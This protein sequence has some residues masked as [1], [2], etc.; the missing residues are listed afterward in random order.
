MVLKDV[1]I[2]LE[3]VPED[4]SGKTTKQKKRERVTLRRVCYQD[5]K[6]RYYVFLTNNLEIPAE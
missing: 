4:E 6:N 5:E 1:I 3:Y 2:E